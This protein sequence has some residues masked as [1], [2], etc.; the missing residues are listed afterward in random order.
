M[1]NIL[2]TVL[3]LFISVGLSAQF[4]DRPGKIQL[5]YQTTANGLVCLVDSIP[6]FTPSD[7]ND[8]YLAQDTLANKLYLFRPSIAT[9]AELAGG[10]G[11]GATELNELLDVTL[12]S[13]ATGEVLRYNGSLWVNDS[14]KSLHNVDSLSFNTSASSVTETGSLGWNNEEQT[15]DLK[16]NGVTL[17]IGQE[18]YKLVKNVSGATIQN[19]QVVRYSGAAGAS[20]RIEADLMIADG[21]YQPYYTI[22]VATED[23]LNG[24]TGF[25]TS[26]GAVRGI[27]T[28]G[29]TAGD[30]LYVDPTTPGAL[31]NIEPTA[32]NQDIPVAIALDSKNNGSIFVRPVLFPALNDVQDVAISNIATGQVLRYDGTKWTN[33]T[34]TASEVT[35]TASGNLTSTN[36]QASLEELQGDIDAISG[37]ASDGVTTAGTYDGANTEIDFTV[38]APGS[39]FS[40]DVSALLDNTDSQQVDTFQIVSNELQLSISND[41]QPAQTVD[42]S[43]YLDNTD[44]QLTQEQV[45]DFAGALFTGNTESLIT[46]TYNDGTGKVDLTVQAALSNYTNDAGFLTSE[47]DGSTTNELQ[48]IS[49][50]TNTLTLSDGGGSADLSGYLDNT[51]SQDLSLSGNTLSLTGDATTVDLSG[52]L[53]NTDAQTLGVTGD[54]ITLTNGGSVSV[55]NTVE[56]NTAAST[57]ITVDLQS[58]RNRIVQV[59]M[60]SASTAS[61]VTLSVSNPVTGG[62]YT[63]HFQN[64]NVGGHDID[65]PANVLQADGTAWDG[66]TTVNYAA[67]DWL[68]CYYD[69]T[70]YHCK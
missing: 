22:G 8:C 42:L 28:S 25:I 1:R 9:W 36:V 59:D 69:G 14:I 26:F 15:L 23:I 33:S 56:S 54:D 31:T 47:V 7:E 34:E 20:S 40:V 45:E 64:T 5:G 43:A 66:S 60:T 21:T 52:Y 57:T 11:S 53:D 17:Q 19:G 29:Y 38:A 2:Y 10:G 6:T 61:T 49:L 62:V 35:N 70:N 44:T 16:I 55:I 24:E 65:F 32:P 39:N 3:A 18:M 30:I 63:F 48:T 41:A 50:L 37:G 51:D 46:S 13:S 58:A 67:D 68:T 27:N 12:T 4:T